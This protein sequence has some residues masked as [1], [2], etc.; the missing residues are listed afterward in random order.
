[1]KKNLQNKNSIGE[2][3]ENLIKKHLSEKEEQLFLI[4]GRESKIREKY[5][6]EKL[7]RKNEQD[8]IIEFRNGKQLNITQLS[9]YLTTAPK[10]YAVT[11]R[12]EFYLPTFKLNSWKIPKSGKISKKPYKMAIYTKRFIYGRFWKEVLP[13]LE[14]LNP[15]VDGVRLHKNFQYLNKEGQKLLE[16]YIDDYI[17]IINECKTWHEFQKKHGLEFGMPFQR[18]FFDKD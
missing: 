11:F 18:S 4:Q 3:K 9:K 12:Q 1:M 5:S 17:R 15:I 7:D 10:E 14:Q 8:K 16:G 13:E 2:A 6:D